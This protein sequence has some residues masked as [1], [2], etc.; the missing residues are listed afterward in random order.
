MFATML[1][2]V[3]LLASALGVRKRTEKLKSQRNALKGEE[4]L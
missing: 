4:R 2:L 3:L 1:F